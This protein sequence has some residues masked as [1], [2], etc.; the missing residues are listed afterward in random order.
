MRAPLAP[1]I[2]RALTDYLD[3]RT[4]LRE[5]DHWFVPA[6]SD[7]EQAVDPA[8]YDLAG[9][10]D[11]RLAEYNRGHWTENE[12]RTVLRP[13]IERTPVVLVSLRDTSTVP[14]PVTASSI[15][16]VNQQFALAR[17]GSHR[18]NERTSA[19]RKPLIEWDPLPARRAV[20]SDRRLESASVTRPV[21]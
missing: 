13:L 16:S 9:E 11:L 14:I 5:F 17:R 7:L 4:S 8:A 3:G 10:I 19:T 20:A 12:L 2:R 1:D 18:A 15:R 6:T 21:R